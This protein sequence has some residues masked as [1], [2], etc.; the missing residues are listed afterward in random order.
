LEEVALPVLVVVLFARMW[1]LICDKGYGTAIVVA[2]VYEVFLVTESDG[3][4]SLVGFE[5]CE[6][7]LSSLDGQ[8]RGRHSWVSSHALRH[9]FG[10]ENVIVIDFA[11]AHHHDVNVQRYHDEREGSVNVID[12]SK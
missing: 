4:V 3:D 9:S 5:T 11:R 7:L 2:R 1:R 12:W 10:Q 6:N 8:N